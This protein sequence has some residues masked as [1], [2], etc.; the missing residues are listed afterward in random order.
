MI[1]RVRFH[2][3]GGQGAKTA[4]RILGNSA[5]MEG[6]YVQDSPLYGAERRGAPVS[7][8]TRISDSPIMERGYISDPDIVVVMDETLLTD[9]VANPLGGIRRGGVVF[10]NTRLSSEK[11]DTGGHEIR[12]VTLDLTDLA[13]QLLGKATLST[14]AAS[15]AA[16]LSFRISEIALRGGVESELE[17]IGVE[18]EII[19]K[20][21]SLAAKVYGDLVPKKLET[22]EIPPKTTLVPFESI[23][24]NPRSQDI[25]SVGNSYE[26]HTGDWRI[27]KPSIDYDK[28]TSCMICY[29]YCPESALTLRPDGKPEIDYDNCKGCLICYR[30]CPPKAITVE[31]EIEVEQ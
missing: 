4:S 15:A 8:F 28:C 29:T 18:K 22:E 2:G 3:R 21:I 6:M 7:A 1:L 30:E 26:K 12:V 27:F 9:V 10:V 31:R 13:L 14:A 25:V 23:V 19:G 17:E 24:N 16:R 11:I 20:N 5:F